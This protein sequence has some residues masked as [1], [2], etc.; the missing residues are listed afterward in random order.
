[1]KSPLR[2]KDF[3]LQPRERTQE[4]I[5][6]SCEMTP[7]SG[8][9]STRGENCAA[10]NESPTSRRPGKKNSSVDHKEFKRCGP[11]DPYI[12]AKFTVTEPLAWLQAPV[13]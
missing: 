1:M 6:P 3:R 9:T 4:P 12:N 5:G 11:F 7:Q 8:N 10:E 13:K 2:L